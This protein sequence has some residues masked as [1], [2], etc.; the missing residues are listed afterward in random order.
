MFIKIANTSDPYQIAMHNIYMYFNSK[1]LVYE[2]CIFIN[3]L[4]L[5][6]NIFPNDEM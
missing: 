4:G 5:S 1:M 3:V 2:F 6:I